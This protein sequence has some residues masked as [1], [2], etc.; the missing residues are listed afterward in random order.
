MGAGVGHDIS[1][2]EDV[3]RDLYAAAEANPLA[4]IRKNRPCP[5]LLASFARYIPENGI[6]AGCGA[7]IL[8]V[9]EKGCNPAGHEQNVA[10]LYTAT[11]NSK[12]HK[13]ISPGA[14]LMALQATGTNVAR[15]MREYNVHTEGEKIE[16]KKRMEWWEG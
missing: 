15:L 9:F 10:V 16:D 12:M 5:G 11:P 3:H 1:A 4:L 2:I 7:A 8:D 6:Y 14:F 13:G